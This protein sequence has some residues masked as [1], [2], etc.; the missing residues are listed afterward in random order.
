M[1]F[2][3]QRRSSQ[4]SKCHFLLVCFLFLVFCKLFSFLSKSK[5]KKLFFSFTYFWNSF[6]V[7]KNF[8][9]HGLIMRLFVTSL[10]YIKFEIQKKNDSNMRARALTASGCDFQSGR[11][12]VTGFALTINPAS[13]KFMYTRKQ[14]H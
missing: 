9:T 3:G 14:K 8:S 10:S 2:Y 12:K 4:Y 6:F 5:A 7:R 1:I 11:I 13:Y